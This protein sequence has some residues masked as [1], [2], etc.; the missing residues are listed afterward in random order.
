L[1]TIVLARE[2]NKVVKNLKVRA[3]AP[4]AAPGLK[5]SSRS[6][7]ARG[8]EVRAV[9]IE[10]AIRLFCRQGITATGIDAIVTHSGVARMTLYKHFGSK[11]ALVAAAL[12]EEGATWRTWFFAR[13]AQ[14][15][16]PPRAR[17]L[18][19]FDA[20]GEW[21]VRDDYFG[22]ALMNA[23]AEYR[24]QSP[25]VLAVTQAHKRPVLEYV[26]SLCDAAGANDPGTLASQIDLL[27]DGAIVKAL[28]RRDARSALEARAIAA[29]LLH[30]AAERG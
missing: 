14:A 9:L 7:G 8:L 18:A 20:L 16:G 15:E 23:V 22:C 6:A 27:M 12:E 3:L 1:R 11:D 2:G 5:F 19:I 26:R 17:L 29:A 30:F 21:F 4:T 13:I 10:T 28:V 24:N 25:T